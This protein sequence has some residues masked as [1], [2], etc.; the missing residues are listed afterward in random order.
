MDA[1]PLRPY[2]EGW[3]GP[4]EFASEE[5][6]QARLALAGFVD[7]ETHLFD[8]PVVQTTY[9]RCRD[10]LEN[11]ILGTHLDRIPP[12]RPE[13]RAQFLDTLASQFTQDDPPCVFDYWRLNIR[14]RRP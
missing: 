9:E 7:V 5:V 3:P 1:E 11:V 2:F 12:D 8:V 4:W 14:A 10:Y 6:T 13:L